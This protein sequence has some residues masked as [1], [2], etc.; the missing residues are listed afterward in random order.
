MILERNILIQSNFLVKGPLNNYIGK[1]RGEGCQWKVNDWSWDK[2][3]SKLGKIWSTFKY[4]IVC[5]VFHNSYKWIKM[6][7]KCGRL[8]STHG[9]LKNQNPW[10]RFGVTC[11]TAM[12]IKLISLNNGPHG[13]NWQYCLAG[14]SKTAPTFFIFSI[15]MGAKPS[16]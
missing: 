16:L 12:P 2:G 1:N 13:L 14:S 5:S 8:I 7:G 3:M 9:N 4:M 6:L 10:E 15:A 11:W